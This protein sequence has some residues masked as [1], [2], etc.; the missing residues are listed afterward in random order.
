MEGP[1]E[2]LLRIHDRILL[3]KSSCEAVSTAYGLDMVVI[4]AGP[5]TATQQGIDIY[6]SIC[7][8]KNTFGDGEVIMQV[9]HPDGGLRGSSGVTT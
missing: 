8:L 5:S 2:G 1:G 6:I 9:Q 3:R 7:I 4:E